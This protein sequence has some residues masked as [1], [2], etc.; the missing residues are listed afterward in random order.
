MVETMYELK[1]QVLRLSD[2][3]DELRLSTGGRRMVT[4][5]VGQPES[6]KRPI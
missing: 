6:D 4:L 1:S 5:E 2:E 3:V